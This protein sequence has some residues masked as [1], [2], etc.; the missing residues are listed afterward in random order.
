MGPSCNRNFTS[1]K[2]G[3]NWKVWRLKYWTDMF[4]RGRLERELE[5]EIQAHLAIE[6]QSRIAGGQSPEE[7]RKAALRDIRSVTAVQEATRDSWTWSS[8]DRWVRDI[9]YAVRT[10]RRSPVFAAVVVLSLAVGIGANTAF[11]SLAD[12]MMFRKLPLEG[13]DELVFFDWTSGPNRLAVDLTGTYS[14]DPSTGR[15]VRTSFLYSTFKVFREQSRTLSDVFAFYPLPNATLSVEGHPDVIPAQL[16]SGNYFT[17]LRVPMWIGRPLTDEDELQRHPV[18]VISYRCWERQFN[19]DAGVLGKTITVNGVPLTVIGVTPSGFNGTQGFGNPTDLSVPLSLEPQFAQPGSL[20]Q[21]SSAWW[22]RVMGRTRGGVSYVKVQAELEGMLHATG[23][24]AYKLLPPSELSN[25]P[26]PPDMPKLRVHSGNRGLTDNLDN[27]GPNGWRASQFLIPLAAISVTLLLTVWVNVANLVLARSSARQKE[28]GVRLALGAGRLRVVRQMLTETVLLSLAGGLFG[29]IAAYWGKDLLAGFIP[30]GG[31]TSNDLRIDPRVLALTALVSMLSGVLFGLAPAL[32]STREDVAPA[33]KSSGRSFLEVRTRWGKVLVTAQVAM[34][35][36][37]L[38]GSG[39]FIRT[40]RNL[41]NVGVGF[42]SNNLLLFRV[43]PG[44]L[45]YDNSRIA[46]LYQAI[47]DRTS[48]LPGVINATFSDFPL[49]INSGSDMR[50]TFGAADPSPKP[51]PVARLRIHP[52]FFDAIG[53]RVVSGR[54]LTPRDTANA[55]KVA[56]VNETFVRRFSPDRNPVGEHFTASVALDANTLGNVDVEIVGVV[57]DVS[58]R[59]VRE[60]VPAAV[61]VPDL[62]WMPPAA[63]FVLRTAGDPLLW[64]PAV[65]EVMNQ[66]DSNLP[67]RAVKTQAEQIEQGFTSERTFAAAAT[68]FGGIAVGLACIGLFG[69]MCYNVERRT[70]EIALHM[71]LGAR[72]SDVVRLILSQTLRVVL[73]GAI[74]G[75]GAAFPVVRVVTAMPFKGRPD[76]PSTI[77]LAV[78]VVVAVASFAAY[79]PARRAASVD[80]VAALRL[81]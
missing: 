53:V 79:L 31:V 11:F 27:M 50:I 34:S 67:L 30:L 57:K 16:V 40:V 36:V 10:L 6:T 60:E 61:F 33:L 47:L 72:P 8:A 52:N 73:A 59:V 75:L 46:A 56:L 2:D 19:L 71:A 55:P 15:Q 78:A 58:I 39:L 66:I 64:V 62:Q 7:A 32:R 5:D 48:T 80:P 1:A 14:K 49:V 54:N 65:R 9:R 12:A 51:T 76:D 63:S 37:L 28:I 45:K 3:M 77:A 70:N 21:R 20:M 69:L 41:Q 17:A 13:V 29:A 42:N 35:V 68:S 4:R 18:A 74:I 43:N 24:E 26:G 81:E 38:V 23:M 25:A 22:L 44:A